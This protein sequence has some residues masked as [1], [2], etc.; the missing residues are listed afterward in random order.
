MRRAR[1]GVSA[2]LFGVGL[3]GLL[4]GIVFHQILQWHSML[5]AKVA[6]H[7]LDAMKTNMRADGWFHLAMWLFIL[8]GI[9]YLASAFRA[10]GRTPTLRSYGGNLLL[11]WGAFNLLEGL[12]NHFVLELHHVRDIPLHMPVYDWVSLAAG[13]IGLALV[14]L[15]LRDGPDPGPVL[16]ERRSGADRRLS[17]SLI[18]E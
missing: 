16:D 6:P 1:F 15:A 2:L 14:G 3:G 12:V 5:S 4:D 10:P 9:F 13:G 17:F 18:K 8:A 11:G 7:T